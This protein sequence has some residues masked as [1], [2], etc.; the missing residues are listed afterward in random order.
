M[1]QILFLYFQDLGLKF[2][3]VLGPIS[4]VMSLISSFQPS[5]SA[6]L[7]YMKK[8]FNRVFVKLDSLDGKVTEIQ[9]HKTRKLVPGLLYDLFHS[10][11]FAV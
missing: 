2:A 10:D 4:A 1:N 11:F 6:E 7:K 8:T 9:L 5:E 3:A